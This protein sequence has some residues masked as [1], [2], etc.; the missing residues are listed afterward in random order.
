LNVAV[1]AGG[2]FAL[3]LLDALAACNHT[4]VGIITKQDRPKGRRH[5]LEPTP[6]GQWAE[7]R[8]VLLL[9]V[10]RVSERTFERRFRSLGADTVFVADFGEILK[11]FV[12]S[13]AEKGFWGVHPSLLPRW[14]GAAPVPWT[15]LSGDVETGVTIFKL[16][17]GM[18]S[19]AIA[20]QAA[21]DVG[22]RESAPELEE[23]LGTLGADL[24]MELLDR[25]DRESVSLEKQTEKRATKAPKLTRE[26][27][28]FDWDESP[29]SLDRKVR[30]LLPWPCAW[31]TWRKGDVKVLRSFPLPGHGATVPGRFLGVTEHKDVGAGAL[32]SCGD[33]ALLLLE[34]LAAGKRALDAHLWVNG[35]RLQVGDSL[36]P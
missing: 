32:V 6:V 28:F 13:W 26:D 27:G 16:S 31:F 29:E 7:E 5:R 33:G 36:Q 14:R 2:E 12:L 23:R 15:I 9:K 20:M 4:V 34:I 24:A 25:L 21:C 19:G 35:L 30:A 22:P 10:P 8:D 17:S 3:P 18:D 11:P 1:I